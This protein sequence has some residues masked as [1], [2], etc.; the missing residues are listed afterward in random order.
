MVADLDE[1]RKAAEKRIKEYESEKQGKRIEKP[2][3][4]VSDLIGYKVIL[5]VREKKIAQDYE[6]IFYSKKVS[7]V[8]AEIDAVKSANDDGWPVVGYVFDISP[9]YRS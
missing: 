9:L 3:P 5:A 7:R 1:I 2:E 6:Y 8:E 4:S